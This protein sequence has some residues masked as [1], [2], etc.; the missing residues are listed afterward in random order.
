MGSMDMPSWAAYL[1][2]DYERGLLTVPAAREM[3]RPSEV[4][5]L[6]FAATKAT[7]IQ[8]EVPIAQK[9]VVRPAVAN[10]SLG[11]YGQIRGG[12]D[13]TSQLPAT[14]TLFTSKS[15]VAGQVWKLARDPNGCR[16]VQCAFETLDPEECAALASELRGHIWEAAR[17]PHANHVVQKCILSLKPKAAQF[18]IDELLNNGLGPNAISQVARHRY[19]CRIVERLIERCEESQVRRLVEGLVPDAVQL[20]KHPYGNYVM[21]HILEHGPS[22]QRSKLTSILVHHAHAVGSDCYARAVVSK[23][24][25]F[26]SPEDQVKL[27]QAL[28]RE[29]GLITTMARTRH[30]H[31]AAKYVLQH[32]D[33]AD[34]AEACRQLSQEVSALRQSR[35]GRFVAACLGDAEGP[36][37]SQYMVQ[38]ALG[39]G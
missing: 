12:Q 39:G 3:R 7:T 11:M 25:A 5:I 13:V 19:G 17:C 28:V 34:R 21:Q 38:A 22:D 9:P 33:G 18:I 16:E 4:E 27:A 6:K 30:G 2:C 29:V 1:P 35:Y 31:V 14:P 8:E 10:P 24:L 37:G 20:A 26:G 36:I 23:A 32:L 15:P